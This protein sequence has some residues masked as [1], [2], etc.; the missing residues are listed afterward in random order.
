M[1]TLYVDASCNLTCMLQ[2]DQQPEVEIANGRT[3]NVNEHMA[4]RRA[5]WRFPGEDL[6]I[7]SD[8]QL[9]VRQINGIYQTRDETL[10]QEVLKTRLEL[11]KRDAKGLHTNIEWIPREQNLAGIFLETRRPPNGQGL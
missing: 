2:Q 3:H 1:R 8:S 7:F 11:M 9:A 5:L 4:I 10:R 6:N